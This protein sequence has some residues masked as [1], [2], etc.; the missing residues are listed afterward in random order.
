MRCCQTWC[1]DPISKKVRRAILRGREGPGARITPLQLPFIGRPP[2]RASEECGTAG[3]RHGTRRHPATRRSPVS[4]A[5]EVGCAMDGR[6]GRRTGAGRAGGTLPRQQVR[7]LRPEGERAWPSARGRISGLR[8]E[9]RSAWHLARARWFPNVTRS[10]LV[11]AAAYP[12]LDSG[13]TILAHVG[14]PRA[15]AL[16][17]RPTCRWRV[18]APLRIMLRR[19]AGARPAKRLAVIAA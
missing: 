19:S 13:A 11:L 2:R 4:R 5:R 18:A 10:C 6:V 1:R 14:A 12:A 9:T 17:R 16:R 15:P 8:R 3:S 7:T